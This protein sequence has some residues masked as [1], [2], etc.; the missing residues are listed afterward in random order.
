MNP[1]LEPELDRETAGYS[2]DREISLGPGTILGIFFVLALICAC[3]FGFGYSVGRRSANAAAI[4]PVL[5]PTTPAA[6]APK[7]AAGSAVPPVPIIV[8]PGDI[9]TQPAAPADATL[10]TEKSNPTPAPIAPSAAT[11]SVPG[12]FMVQVAAVS[13]Q[14]IADIEVS[15]L[16][17]DGYAVVVRHEPQDKL[18]HVQIGPFTDKKEAEAMRQRVQADGFNAIVK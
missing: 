3:F 14:D 1:L 4:Q 7:P 9:A 11:P 16:K 15:A 17:K 8:R 13:S 5:I 10:A 18:L 6:T 12:S 2:N